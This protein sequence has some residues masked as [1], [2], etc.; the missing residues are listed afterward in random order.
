MAGTLDEKQQGREQARCEAQFRTVT[1]KDALLRP[2]E[3]EITERI[4]FPD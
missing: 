1:P 2:L 4:A 3:D